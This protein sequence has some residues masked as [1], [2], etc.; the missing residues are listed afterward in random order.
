MLPVIAEEQLHVGDIAY[1]W[2]R[3]AGGIGAASMA[4]FLAMK[5]ITRNIGKVLLAVVGLLE[6]EQLFLVQRIFMRWLFWR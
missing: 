2:L 6:Q 4:I 3:A 1:G 5:P